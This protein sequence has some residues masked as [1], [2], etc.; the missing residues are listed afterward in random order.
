MA[1]ISDNKNPL[2]RD[3]TS[4]KTL[5]NIYKEVLE[6]FQA[7]F[8]KMPLDKKYLSEELIE[9]ICRSQFKFLAE[10]VMPEGKGYSLRIKY[11]GIFGCT[12]QR[13]QQ[14]K[15]YQEWLTPAQTTDQ[16]NI[17]INEDNPKE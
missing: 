17:T 5:E 13:L 3:T 14:M 2:Y 1:S 12:N 11:L 8:G 7:R 16:N 6:E 10:K 15:K 9:S 4:E